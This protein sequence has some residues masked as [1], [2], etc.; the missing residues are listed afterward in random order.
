[1]E[2]FTF[3]SG[4]RYKTG[5]A[6]PR[7]L[8]APNLTNI[9]I[10]VAHNQAFVAQMLDIW[11]GYRLP[12]VKTDATVQAWANTPMQFWQNQLNFAVWCATAGCG[13][14][15]SD[16]LNGPEAHKNPLLQSVY[17]F[18]VYYT[19]RRILKEMSIALPQDDSSDPINNAYNRIA[20]ERL[21][22]EFGVHPETDWRQKEFLNSNGLGDVHTK[23]HTAFTQTDFR[24]DGPDK[25][26]AAKNAGNLDPTRMTFGSEVSGG[27]HCGVSSCDWN[28]PKKAHIDF[29]LQDDGV[30]GAWSTFV[31]DKSKGLTEAGMAR[32]DDSIR[33]YVWALLGAQAQTKARITDSFEARKQ[34]LSNVEDAINSP[35]NISDSITRY[36]KVLQYAGSEVNYLFGQGLYMAPSNMILNINPGIAGYNNLILKGPADLP[37][38]KV[39]VQKDSIVP[40]NHGSFQDGKIVGPPTEDPPAPTPD[41][42]VLSTDLAQARLHEEEKTALVVGGIALGLLALWSVFR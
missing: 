7:K 34:F 6:Y 36:Q 39:D 17:V 15:F 31:L 33:T 23:G 5:A 26:V 32:I 8:L 40:K 4:V 28:P 14:S 9:M 38:G 41:P 3:N 1:M 42:R 13:V 18:H 37:L 25:H 21:C 29:I 22:S 27:R 12:K 16:H 10:T 30:D 35:I 19:T 11:K 24:H 2:V 20:Y